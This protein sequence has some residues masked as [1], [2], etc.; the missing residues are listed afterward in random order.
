MAL[1]GE[2]TKDDG[3]SI[4]NNNNP[5]RQQMVKRISSSTSQAY[6][7]TADSPN[8]GVRRSGR[9]RNQ[10]YVPNFEQNVTSSDEDKNEPEKTSCVHE[11]KFQQI[12]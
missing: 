9:S 3:I 4:N 12:Y 7:M 1:R 6:A 5:E 8:P 11:L 2:E 10:V